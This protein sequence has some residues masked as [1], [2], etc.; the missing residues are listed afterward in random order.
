MKTSEFYWKKF[1]VLLIVFSM[2]FG[3]GFFGVQTVYYQ[4]KSWSWKKLMKKPEKKIK[5]VKFKINEELLYLDPVLLKTYLDNDSKDFSLIDIRSKTEFDSGHIKK[6]QSN[7]LYLDYK[8]PYE[9]YVN[10][11]DWLKE[12]KSL[13]R[14]KKI[15][16]LYGYNHEADMILEVANLLKENNLKVKI[17][18]V[19][20][21]DWQNNFYQW[22]PGAA[23]GG[24]APPVPIS[25]PVD[26]INP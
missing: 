3:L 20:W 2:G 8:N 4:S 15:I 21:N 7:P 9:T 25:V 12:T 10:G 1:L 5:T 18:G 6:A 24:M 23:F 16:I 19:N 13:S 17:L 14:G 22:M 11:N 26:S